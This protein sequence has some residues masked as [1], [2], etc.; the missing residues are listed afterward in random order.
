MHSLHNTYMGGCS[1]DERARG[2]CIRVIGIGVFQLNVL[3]LISVLSFAPHYVDE[4]I[5]TL[6]G[7]ASACDW[8]SHGVPK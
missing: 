5:A 1:H 7:L 6:D 8:R 3:H 2:F 4:I